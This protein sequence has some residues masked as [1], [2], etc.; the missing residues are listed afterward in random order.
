MRE[1]GSPVHPPPPILCSLLCFWLAGFKLYLY[2]C[3]NSLCVGGVKKIMAYLLFDQRRVGLYLFIQMDWD[4]ILLQIF[5]PLDHQGSPSESYLDNKH[6]IV[7]KVLSL[8]LFIFISFGG[9][10]AQ[11]TSQTH[12]PCTGKC[13]VLTTGPPGTSPSFLSFRKYSNLRKRS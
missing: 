5:K 12:I 1:L 9:T 3:F 13:G 2:F 6:V 11:R 10:M 4:F 7:S 8:S